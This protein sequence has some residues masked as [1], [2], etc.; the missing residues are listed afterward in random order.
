MYLTRIRFKD[1]STRKSVRDLG[2]VYE[3]HRTVLS[4]FGKDPKVLYRLEVGYLL[5]LSS[6]KPSY[7]VDYFEDVETKKY[8]M[9]YKKDQSL[10]FRMRCN[11]VK[12]SKDT[13][14]YYPVI[15]EDKLKVWLDKRATDNGFE[16]VRLVSSCEDPEISYKKIGDKEIKQTHHSVLMNGI[17]KIIDEEKFIHALQSGI[18]RARSYGFGLLSVKLV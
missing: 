13:G 17:I 16:V 11:A 12:R 6:K 4:G 15:E 18:G 7:N 2:S 10:A 9:Q 1:I 5:I 8:N 14:K 3:M